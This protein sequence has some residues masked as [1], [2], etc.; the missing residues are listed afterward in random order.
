MNNSLDMASLHSYLGSQYMYKIPQLHT[1]G[2]QKGL[3]K[4]FNI[5]IYPS[6]G[7]VDTINFKTF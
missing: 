4:N 5:I 3:A 7:T 1:F 2:F 6:I